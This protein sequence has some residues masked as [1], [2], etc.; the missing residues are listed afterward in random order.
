MGGDQEKRQGKLDLLHGVLLE[1]L[2]TD[3]V[4]AGLKL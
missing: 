3:A 1:I 4:G 2:A